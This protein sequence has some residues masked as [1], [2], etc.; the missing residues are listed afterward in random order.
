MERSMLEKKLEEKMREFA[1][2]QMK[3]DFHIKETTLRFV[4]EALHHLTT[5]CRHALGLNSSCF[6]ILK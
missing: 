3:F 2:L 5:S 6:V 4:F 1:D